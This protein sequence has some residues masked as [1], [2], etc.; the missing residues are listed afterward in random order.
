MSFPGTFITAIT[1]VASAIISLIYDFLWSDRT[2]YDYDIED[3]NDMNT[4]SALSITRASVFSRDGNT[5]AVATKASFINGADASNVGVALFEFVNDQWQPLAYLTPYPTWSFGTGSSNYTADFGDSLCFSG[6]GNTLVVSDLGDG[7]ND[8]SRGGALYVFEKGAG[9]SDGNTNLSA[10]LKPTG[11]IGNDY[12]CTGAKTNYDGTVITGAAGGDNGQTGTLYV[13]EKGAGWSNGN[14]SV[15]AQLTVSGSSTGWNIGSLNDISDDGNTIV[16]AS[17]RAGDP[18]FY[19]FKKGS[20]W[21]TTSTPTYTLDLPS[22]SNS[23]VSNISMSGD[24]EYIAI[25]MGNHSPINEAGD[26][27]FSWSG[28]GTTTGMMAVYK[29]G[30]GWVTGSSNYLTALFADM[31][32]Y[33]EVDDSYYLGTM[34]KSGNTI[35]ADFKYN[36]VSNDHDGGI[37]I[38]Q[39]QPDEEW[40]HGYTNVVGVIGITAPTGNN[41]AGIS[42]SGVHNSSFGAS[43]QNRLSI[44]GNASMISGQ[45]DNMWAAWKGTDPDA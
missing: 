7:S 37:I 38:F 27:V 22:L 9:W 4:P 5:M 3:Q 36:Y 10:R 24:G 42:D 18:Y 28:L 45:P 16:T 29:R 33:G 26:A 35:V 2:S 17:C 19:I 20:S 40:Q 44:A 32:V 41:R 11:L 12:F 31:A 1:K 30:S 8:T 23:S 21:S 13:F 39:K 43:E 34:S 25:S 6:D 15:S 14:S